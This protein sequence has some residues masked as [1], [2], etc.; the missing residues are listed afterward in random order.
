MRVTF[1]RHGQ[2]LGNASGSIDSSTPGPVLSALGYQQ[3]AAVAAKL[4]D[5]NY[6]G[7]Y[8]SSMVRTQLT[9]TPL[10]QYLGLPIHVLDGLQEIEAGDYE[11]TPESEAASGYMLA[12]L[13]WSLQGNLDA[14]IPGSIDGHE[15]DARMDSALQAI[16]DSGDRNAAVF[17]HG[18]AMMFW[19]FMNVE[20]LTAAQKMELLRASLR[21]TADVVI[22]GNSED[23]W[24]LVSWDGREFSEGRTFFGEVGVQLRTLVRQVGAEIRSVVEAFATRDLSVVVKAVNRAVSTAAFSVIK[25]VRAVNADVVERIEKAVS[26]VFPKSATPAVPQ[27][28]ADTPA[29]ADSEATMTEQV[30]VQPSATPARARNSERTAV[31]VSSSTAADVEKIDEVGEARDVMESGR[32]EIEPA[33]ESEVTTDPGTE[34]KTDAPA[35]DG[36]DDRADEKDTDT[37]DDRD[38]DRDTNRDADDKVSVGSTS[39]GAGSDSDE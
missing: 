23:G 4:G 11:G 5:K 1:I 18:A 36:S 29:V 22:E 6:D 12:P 34:E 2:S 10:S 37:A 27:S 16:Y 26:R 25:F 13:A 33:V 15:F 32:E 31:L 38:A 20:N 17:S 7:V 35:T 30:D 14:R 28:S 21:N 3:A 24:K 39:A 8:A 19:T 9:A